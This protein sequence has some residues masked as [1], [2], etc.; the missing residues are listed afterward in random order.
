MRATA[1]C[2]NHPASRNT[3]ISGTTCIEKYDAAYRTDTD[4]PYA[5]ASLYQTGDLYYGLYRWSHIR[6][7]KEKA[8]T[9]LKTTIERYPDSSYAKKA[10]S[11]IIAIYGKNNSVLM[12]LEKKEVPIGLYAEQSDDITKMIQDSGSAKTPAGKIPS[13]ADGSMT[14]V[15][16]LRSW[17]NPGYTRIVIDA[18]R[19][20]NYEHHILKPDPSK[21][22][23]AAAVR[24]SDEQQAEKRHRYVGA[25]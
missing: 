25:H 11:K 18:D 7:D 24:G 6:A 17:S 14:I 22:E 19:K 5:A 20:T 13:A 9:R 4:G 15:Q 21:K 23:T 10:E 1:D 8:T 3:E 2:A 12:G 16:G